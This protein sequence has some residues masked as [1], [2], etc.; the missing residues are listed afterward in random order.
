[1]SAAYAWSWEPLAM[2]GE[3]MPEGL[4]LPNQMAYTAMRSL[5]WAFHDGKISRERAAAEKKLIRLEFERCE[6]DWAFWAKLAVRQARYFK[7]TELAGTACRKDPTP[8]NALRLCD[9]LVGLAEMEDMS[10]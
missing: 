6:G 8:E 3:P 4:D 5:Y 9:V 1:M 7:G 2:K 10:G